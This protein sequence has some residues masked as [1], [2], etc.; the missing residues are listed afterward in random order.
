MTETPGSIYTGMLSTDAIAVQVKTCSAKQLAAVARQTRS[1]LRQSRKTSQLST[2]WWLATTLGLM[3]NRRIY[4]YYVASTPQ[5][6]HTQ[7]RPTQ[8]LRPTGNP[9][10]CVVLT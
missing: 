7:T 6:L 9:L 3:A 1:R 5:L 8:T 4:N 10:T 2:R